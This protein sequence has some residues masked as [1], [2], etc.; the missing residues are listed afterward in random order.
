MADLEQ[1]LRDFIEYNFSY[2][3]L[4]HEHDPNDHRHDNYAD[5]DHEHGDSFESQ[6]DYYLSNFTV[7][8]GCATKLAFE[9]AVRVIIADHLQHELHPDA[10]IRSMLLGTIRLAR[11]LPA[12]RVMHILAETSTRLTDLS[13]QNVHH[14]VCW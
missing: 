14:A 5:D 4:D 9:N 8:S 3:D 6:V 10:I 11:K 7:G 13:R 2:A 12:D 1:A